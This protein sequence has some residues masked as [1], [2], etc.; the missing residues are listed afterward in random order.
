MR[1]RIE[2]ASDGIVIWSGGQT[3]VDRAALDVAL[4]LG[5]LSGGWLPHGRMAEDGPLPDRYAGM[6]ETESARPDV[7]T[8]RNVRDSDATLIIAFGPLTGGS[9]LTRKAAELHGKPALVVDLRSSP[10]D[11]AVQRTRA[12]LRSLP[13]PLRLNVAGPRESTAP[14]AYD[15]AARFLHTLLRRRP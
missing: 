13:R 12:W 8:R 1:V 14:G 7:R 6:L 3:G 2:D 11:D 10:L 15:E 5:M 4:A 9:A